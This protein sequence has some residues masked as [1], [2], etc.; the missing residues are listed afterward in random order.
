MNDDQPK[1]QTHFARAIADA[2]LEAKG[3]FAAQRPR[4]NGT[5]PTVPVPGPIPIWGQGPQPGDEP[6]TGVAIDDLE[7]P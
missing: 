7:Q 4:I 2:A 3:R 5:E 6:P 1:P